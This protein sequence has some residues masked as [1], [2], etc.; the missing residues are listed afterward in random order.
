MSVIMQ[1][2]SKDKRLSL[3]PLKFREVITDVL[4]V[5]PQPKRKPPRG[6]KASRVRTKTI[7]HGM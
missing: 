2:K 3:Y 1:E 7:R 4:K 6:K 5:K